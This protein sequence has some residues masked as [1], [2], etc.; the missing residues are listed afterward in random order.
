MSLDHLYVSAQYIWLPGQ[1]Y[2]AVSR[3]RKLEGLTVA[4]FNGRQI[5]L[6]EA[7]AAWYRDVPWEHLKQKPAPKPIGLKT[8]NL[9]EELKHWP[10]SSDEGTDTA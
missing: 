5:P 3:A 9:L 2:T 4:D 6:D 7:V 8:R 10:S 1:F